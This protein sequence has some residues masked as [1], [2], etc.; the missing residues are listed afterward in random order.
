MANAVLDQ[1][2]I[3]FVCVCGVTAVQWARL[4]NGR[5]DLG[6]CVELEVAALAFAAPLVFTFHSQ[7]ADAQCS[8][9]YWLVEL[10]CDPVVQGNDKDKLGGE[11]SGVMTSSCAVHTL[12]RSRLVLLN[13]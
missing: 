4:R 1:A 8:L 11:S 7:T 3:D 6:L 9:A 5:V 10:K 12:R 13:S 2:V